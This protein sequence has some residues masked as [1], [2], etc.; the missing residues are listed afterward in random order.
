MVFYDLIADEPMR[1][2]FYQFDRFRASDGTDA[3]PRDVIRYEPGIRDK[4]GPGYTA[5][6]RMAPGATRGDFVRAVSSIRSVC[7]A[8]IAIAAHD[9]EETFLILAK[10]SGRDCAKILSANEGDEASASNTR[11]T[12]E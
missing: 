2:P 5:M 8:D 4:I 12:A 10:P 6:F 3:A 9:Q 7:D 1:L 11:K